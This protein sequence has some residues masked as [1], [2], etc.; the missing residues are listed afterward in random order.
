MIERVGIYSE[1]FV[2]VTPL[3]AFSADS[4][5]LSIGETFRLRDAVVAQEQ[6]EV[7]HI[8]DFARIDASLAGLSIVGSNLLKSG[9]VSLKFDCSK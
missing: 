5:E 2:A 1:P 4:D 8:A 9:S 3:Y 7:H 6:A